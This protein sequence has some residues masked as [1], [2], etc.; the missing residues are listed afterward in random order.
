MNPEKYNLT[1]YIQRDFCK[2]FTFVDE[3]GNLIPID[4]WVFKSQIRSTKCQ[5]GTLLAEFTIDI[6]PTTSTI[7]LNLSDSETQLLE[8]GTYFWD[9]LVEMNGCDVNLLE[10]KVKVLCTVTEK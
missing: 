4:S 7:T 3:E 1:L 2:D 9:L 5:D 10:G 8:E 6:D